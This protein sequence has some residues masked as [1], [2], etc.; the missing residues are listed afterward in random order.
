MITLQLHHYN[1]TTIS[2]LSDATTKL[3]LK[4]KTLNIILHL[5]ESMENRHHLFL[6]KQK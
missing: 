5:N 6:C 3:R 2:L 1:C 4:K